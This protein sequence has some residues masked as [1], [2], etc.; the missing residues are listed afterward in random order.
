MTA[1]ERRI[2]QLEKLL[3]REKETNS[4]GRNDY[5]IGQTE[6]ELSQ[7][8]R[9]SGVAEKS[10]QLLNDAYS[11]LHD[12]NCKKGR[13]TDKLINLIS[14]YINNPTAPPMLQLPS[15]IKYLGPLIML[16]GYV[17]AYIA[18]FTGK[19]SYTYFLISLFGVFLV[20]LVATSFA[21]TA[22]ARGVGKGYGPSSSSTSGSS[23]NDQQGE[24]RT[25][26][27]IIDDARAELALANLFYSTKN[28]K[29]MEMHLEKA[30]MYL[31][32]PASDRSGKKEQA[33][34]LLNKLENSAK[35][36]EIQ[37]GKAHVPLF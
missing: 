22:Y 7:L 28:Y 8:Y 33:A 5:K 14:Y 36:K 20:S 34:E 11:I 31:S 23:I 21:T 25:P 10:K 27:D 19:L 18:Y 1:V 2:S 30:R 24:D 4:D 9:L 35:G 26:D 37:K 15:S 12:P 29:E 13:K 16:G 32:D 6:F 3:E 17:A